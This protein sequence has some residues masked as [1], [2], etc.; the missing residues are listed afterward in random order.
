MSTISSNRESKDTLS[1]QLQAQKEQKQRLRD[2]HEE[3]MD[4]LKKSYELER[5]ATTDRFESSAQYEKL[6]HYDQ[7]RRIK[8]QAQ[9]EESDLARRAE[10]R[11][12][13]VKNQY[14][15]SLEQETK[16]GE[17]Q[18]KDTQ[19]KNAAKLEYENQKARDAQDF[20]KKNF[21]Q[22]A[23]L[24]ERDAQEKL[25]KYAQSKSAAVE[26]ERSRTATAIGQIQTH[27]ENER[28]DAQAHYQAGLA[29]LQNSVQSDLDQKRLTYA[30]NLSEYSKRQSDPFYRLVRFENELK[31]DP[32]RYTLKLKIPPHERDKLR[33]QVVGQDL[34]VSGI[35][36]TQE[37]TEVSPGHWVSTA[38]FQNFS[39]RFPLEYP[40]DASTLMTQQQGDWVEYSLLK[41]GP[42][43]HELSQQL[44]TQKLN[45]Q[46]NAEL[47]SSHEPDFPSTLPQPSIQP[48]LTSTRLTK[49]A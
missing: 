29:D 6:Q 36:S 32:N 26:N 7:L 41:R 28:E 19:L 25:S 42:G 23:E 24:I 20:A 33:V 35:R 10:E 17:G 44:L 4:R 40:V 47:A 3:E 11:Q 49:K 31:Q 22:N 5:A 27:F 16:A 13:Q 45:R 37:K 39:E 38:T 46:P 43:Y 2:Q 14:D 12:S 21:S 1:E 18:L 30:H 9:N 15:H 48:T 34:V 8:K